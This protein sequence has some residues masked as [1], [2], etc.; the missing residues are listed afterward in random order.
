MIDSLS[1]SD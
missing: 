1:I